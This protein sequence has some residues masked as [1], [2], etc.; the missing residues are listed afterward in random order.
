MR[1]EILSSICKMPEA[2]DKNAK[3]ASLIQSFISELPPDKRRVFWEI[4][5]AI[6]DYNTFIQNELLKQLL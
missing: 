3:C 2:K 4:E 6:S 1:I 5:I